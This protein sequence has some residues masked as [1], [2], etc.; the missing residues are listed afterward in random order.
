MNRGEKEFCFIICTNDERKYEECE[1][2]IKRLWVPE[3]Y[4]MDV[5]TIT[6]AES[7]CSAYNAG[8]N[9]SEAKYKIYMHHD[10]FILNRDFLKHLLACFEKDEEIGMI[11]MVG[12]EK[13]PISGVM[14]DTDR[15]GSLYETHVHETVRLENYRE[16]K[17]ME[18]ALIDGFLM[19]TQYDVPWK[20]DVFDKWDFYDA[21]QSMEF[22]RAGYKVVVPYQENPWCLHDCGYVSLGNYDVEREKFVR[23]YQEEIRKA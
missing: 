9:A 13:V 5:I 10:V 21:S 22:R 23:E 4:T 6:G 19:A 15:Y 7:I 18:V 2:Y 12:A 3:G 1:A 16:R 20:E 17:D 11:G 8:M 14:W